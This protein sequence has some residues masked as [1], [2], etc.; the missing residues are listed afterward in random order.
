[1][2]QF[3]REVRLLLENDAPISALGFQSRFANQTPPETIYKRLQ[4]F[5][6]FNLPIAATEF[7]MKG[8]DR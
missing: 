5:E 6:K 2:K 4:Y 8:H 7:E 3:E 1:M